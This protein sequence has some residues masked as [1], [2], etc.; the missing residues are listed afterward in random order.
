MK[1]S[2]H[3]QQS[4]FERDAVLP[5]GCIPIFQMLC[6]NVLEPIRTYAGPMLI[7][8]GYRPPDANAA[9]HGVPNSQHIA[10]PADCAADFEVVGTHDLRHLF[11]W[12]RKKSGLP[13]D[14]LIFEHQK[15]GGPDILHVSYVIEGPRREALEGSTANAS[16]YMHTDFNGPETAADYSWTA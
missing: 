7:T 11:D 14:Q 1:L 5:F 4:E 12:I 9:A 3:F 2:E 16:T 10:T 8:S 6:A 13:I 15:N